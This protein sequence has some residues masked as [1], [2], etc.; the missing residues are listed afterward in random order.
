MKSGG[1]EGRSL[2][3]VVRG[4]EEEAFNQNKMN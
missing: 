2:G 1:D 4:G 3:G